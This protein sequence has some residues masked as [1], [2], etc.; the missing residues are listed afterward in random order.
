[1]EKLVTMS[2]KELDRVS[3]LEKV[4]L[5]KLTK[6][7]AAKSLD[8]SRQHLHRI[9]RRF[10]KEGATALISKRRG[11]ISNNRIPNSV[12]ESVLNII[13]QHYYDFGPS[14][15]N[16]KLAEAHGITISRE[17]VRQLMVSTGLWQ[18]KRRKHPKVHQM[19]VRR[20]RYGELIQIDGSP[21]DWFEGRS[22]PCCLLVLVDDATSSILGLRFVEHEC[23]D[24]YFKLIREYIN[25]CGRP[26]S[27][28]SDR[29]TIFY[30]PNKEISSTAFTGKGLSQ[31]E[32]AMIALDIELIP[33]YSPQAKGRVERANGTLQDRLI[34]EMRLAHISDM[35]AANAWLPLFIKK[36]NQ[37]FAKAPAHPAD[38]H[39]KSLPKK[40][41]L[42]LIF[43][44]QEVRKLSKNLEISYGNVI[45]QIITKRPGY[46]MRGAS[47]TV[48]ET[49]NT[50]TL[51][52]KGRC[53]DYK[54]FDKG[55]HQQKHAVS[56]K[57][58]NAYFDQRIDKRAYGG[59]RKA[60]S[61][62]PWR[63]IFAKPELAKKV[64]LTHSQDRAS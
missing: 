7:S 40:E 8:I 17:T 21:H 26:L 14:F 48:C 19:R 62:H 46:A 1:M 39:R 64:S 6:T 45:Y 59:G 13:R 57:D 33:A 41:E 61:S 52:Y 31:F 32:R 63:G 10:I 36:Y 3:I 44:R 47:I 15:A 25:R 18:G 29:H 49:E 23:L 56:G 34:K 28:Y 58:L 54:V 60:K 35:E 22:S 11:R 24:G 30:A 16:E 4:K 9:Y 2:L 51:L 37:K 43:C 53:L 20:P 38:A 55:R 5:G 42:D 50:I 12:R 27:F